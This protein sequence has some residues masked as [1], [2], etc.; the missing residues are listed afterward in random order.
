MSRVSYWAISRVSTYHLNPTYNF[1]SFGNQSKAAARPVLLFPCKAY[2]QQLTPLR[3]LHSTGS[4]G[5]ASR[6]IEQLGFSSTLF[7]IYDTFICVDVI[8]FP[9]VACIHDFRNMFC[10]MGIS[11][12]QEVDDWAW[13][14]ASPFAPYSYMHR[15]VFNVFP[16][17]KSLQKYLFPTNQTWP[18][19]LA[20]ARN[21]KRKKGNE[22]RPKQVKL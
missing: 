3:P 18:V 2:G 6:Q 12:D 19:I 11:L 10:I 16:P 14:S 20:K 4:E 17:T 1:S 7:F 15:R 21:K 8:Y 5:L 22:E 13:H 9:F